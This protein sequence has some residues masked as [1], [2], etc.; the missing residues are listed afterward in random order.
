M[1]LSDGRYVE[2]YGRMLE[3][4]LPSKY[5]VYLQRV[6]MRGIPTF[7]ADGRCR[8]YLQVRGSMW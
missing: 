2:Y 7:E 1:G 5:P 4:D 6:I 3:G 8:P